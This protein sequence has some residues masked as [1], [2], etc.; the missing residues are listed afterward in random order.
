MIERNDRMSEGESY[1]K[2]IKYGGAAPPPIFVLVSR[3]YV[4]YNGGKRIMNAFTYQLDL[5]SF[6]FLSALISALLTTHSK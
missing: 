2:N 5:S 1:C 6:F 3:T 4:C